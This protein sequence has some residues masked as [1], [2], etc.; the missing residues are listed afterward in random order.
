MIFK[1]EEEKGIIPFEFLGVN[2]DYNGVD[3]KQISHYI[4]M[5]CE[6]YINCIAKSHY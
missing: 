6:R 2:F 1:D 4:V 5:S 3:I